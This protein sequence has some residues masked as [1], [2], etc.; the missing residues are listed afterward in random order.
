MKAVRFSFFTTDCLVREMGRAPLGGG[1]VT[2]VESL[3]A[4]TGRVGNWRRVT[5]HQPRVTRIL[6]AST[7]I[8]R[9]CVEEGSL[10]DCRGG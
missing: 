3:R 8:T 5:G 6:S 7:N 4:S 9:V 2:T 10:Y 1:V